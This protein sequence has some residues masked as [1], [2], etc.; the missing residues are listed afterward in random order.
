[1][2]CCPHCRAGRSGRT[3]GA[4]RKKVTHEVGVRSGRIKLEI[5]TLANVMRNA[6]VPGRNLW[7]GE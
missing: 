7:P 4:T 3:T 1:M 5:V 2:R 6:A